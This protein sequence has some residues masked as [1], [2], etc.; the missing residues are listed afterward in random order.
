M[1]IYSDNKEKYIL[2]GHLKATPPSLTI[3]PDAPGENAPH[4]DAYE[5]SDIIYNYHVP[6][7]WDIDLNNQKDVDLENI[8]IESGNITD[9]NVIQYP[10]LN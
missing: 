1:K 9:T 4:M 3:T 5:S 10:Y 2:V 6:E 8:N 7:M